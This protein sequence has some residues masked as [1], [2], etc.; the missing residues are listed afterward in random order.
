MAMAMASARSRTGPRLVAAATTAIVVVLGVALP[1]CSSS[2]EDEPSAAT[3][4]AGSPTVATAPSTRPVTLPTAPASLPSTTTTTIGPPSVAQ[5][6]GEHRRQW[7][8][9]RPER[10]TFTYEVICA[11]GPERRGPFTVT[12]D[13]GEIG[14]VSVPP[15]IQNEEVPAQGITVDDLFER[16]SDAIGSATVTV[17]YDPTFAF[18]TRIVID[19]STGGPDEV[20]EYQVTAFAPA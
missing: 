17:E 11:C 9:S 15:E 2:D 20:L 14:S 5:I 4:E 7:N 18:P 16:A 1:A 6:L 12:V 19:P 13:D 8:L 3:V 10:Y